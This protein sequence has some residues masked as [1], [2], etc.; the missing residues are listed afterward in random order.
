MVAYSFV[1]TSHT[2]PKK[3]IDG[4]LLGENSES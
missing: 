1:N 2:S 3:R 4:V